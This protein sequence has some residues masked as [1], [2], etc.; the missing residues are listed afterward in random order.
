MTIIFVTSKLFL[1]RRDAFKRIERSRA[2]F[3]KDKNAKNIV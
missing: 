2:V 3:K 1:Q